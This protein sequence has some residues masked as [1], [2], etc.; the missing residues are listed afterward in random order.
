MRPDSLVNSKKFAFDIGWV[1]ISSLISLLVAFLLRVILARKLGAG[2]LGLYT[3]ILTIQEITA[4]VAGLGI[5][6]ALV[7]YI[8]QYKEN[9]NKLRQFI[10]ASFSTTLVFSLF[11]SV[12]L[13]FLAG[14]VADI[15][16]MAPL[17]HLL[18]IFALAIPFS[19]V[20]DSIGGLFN[21][22]RLMKNWA[23]LLILR[24][25]L[26]TLL[27]VILVWYGFGIEGAV[28]GIVISSFI[29]CLTS[30][31]LSRKY[32]HLIFE[33]F[34]ETAKEL[35]PFGIQMFGA[36]AVSLVINRANIMIVGYYLN[37]TELGYYG[38]VL[39]LAG[40]FDIIPQAIQRISYPATT[41]YWRNNDRQS[42]LTM[43]D[44][45]MKYSALIL[46][47]AALAVGFFSK[48][49]VSAIFGADFIG[50]TLPLQIILITKV[51]NGAIL[52]PVGGSLS[53]IGRPDMALKIGV[54]SAVVDV[55]LN[56]LLVPKFGII[57]A[58]WATT[59]SQLVRIIIY[60]FFL[61][62]LAGIKIDIKWFAWVLGITGMAIGAFFIGTHF[63][64]YF[65][66]GGVVLLVFIL[67]LLTLFLTKNDKSYFK[68][69]AGSLPLFRRHS[70]G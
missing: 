50:A 53:G 32:L 30:M 52:M 46:L 64:N 8:A 37:S 69:L 28:Y 31:Y 7:K 21:G 15:F 22:L 5:S 34:S 24:S 70:Q 35:V 14:V 4:L 16:S 25:C 60:M 62:I 3:M 29:T 9:E 45:L 55:G 51:L 38:V 10:S 43:S 18:R 65:L 11:I 27:V 1:L 42:L 20:L 39:T 26:M 61:Y 23:F 59:L 57:G 6:A 63:I 36:N 12:G 41:E 47:P 17:T 54:V 56:I 58:A 48:D 49:I 44:K 13:Y 68:A 40:V 2:D 33:N 66:I 19:T 67:L